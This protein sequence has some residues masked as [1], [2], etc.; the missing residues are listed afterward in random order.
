MG[1]STKTTTIFKQWQKLPPGNSGCSFQTCTYDLGKRKSHLKFMKQVHSSHL[2]NISTTSCRAGSNTSQ[3]MPCAMTHVLQPRCW[4]SARCCTWPEHPL[5]CAW[6]HAQP[7]QATG[8]EVWVCTGHRLCP[9]P[10]LGS[11]RLPS[12]CLHL[13]LRA[14]NPDVWPT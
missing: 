9:S 14:D 12:T 1:S 7:T 4:L 5:K 3:S 6:S 8:A 2:G 11:T 10:K 13:C